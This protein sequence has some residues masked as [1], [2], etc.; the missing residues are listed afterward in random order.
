[1]IVQLAV[2]IGHFHP[3]LVHLP[4]GILIFAFILE[5][6]LRNKKTEASEDIIKFA[7]GI[8]AL[9]ALMSLG[10]G[11]LLGD[12]GGYD[13]TALFR[14]KWMAVAMTVCSI[15]L[16]LLKRNST[17]WSQKTYFPLF[18]ITL[19]LLGITGHLGGN[20][21]HGEGYLFQEKTSEE[22]VITDVNSAKVYADIIQ[23]IFDNKCVSC[24]NPKKAKGELLMTDKT[25]LLAGGENGSILDSVNGNPSSLLTRIHLDVADEEHMPPKGKVQLTEEEITLLDWWMANENCFDCTAGFLNKD[26]HIKTI[27]KSL[28]KDTSTWGILAEQVGSVPDEWIDQM[29]SL[30]LGTERLDENSPL[31]L[32]NLSN[33]V[34][35]DKDKLSELKKYAENV[36]ELNLGYSGFNDTMANGISRFKNLTK[37]QLQRTKITDKTIERLKNLTYLESLNLYGTAITDKSLGYLKKMKSLRSLYLY[38]TSITNNQLAI[39]KTEAPEVTYKH[40]DDAIFTDASLNKPYVVSGTDFFH[41]TQKIELEHAFKS[42]NLYYTTDNSEPN[43]NSKKYVGPIT[44]D[45]STTIKVLAQ[46]DDWKNSEVLTAKFKKSGVAYDTVWLNKTPHKNY[47]GKGG[48]T[49]VDLTRGS[50]SFQDGKWLG[51][52]GTHFKTTMTLKE[53]KEIST[54]S[55]GALT[56]P[57]SWIFYPVGFNVWTS[58]NGKDYKLISTKQNPVQKESN[59]VE[60]TFF[61]IEFK[62]TM[63]RYVKLEI[64]SI[65]KNPSWHPNPGGESW[66]FVDEI[67]IN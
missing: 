49:L 21:T 66:V 55:V 10:T 14:H 30:G 19:A 57:S 59:N 7:L 15:L 63:A 45:E 35:I 4:I 62:P 51:F 9:S 16:Y 50:S 29:N 36:V 48:K 40:L 39:F 46:K 41:D 37:L 32:V 33:K 20:M 8:A 54:V 5:I 43:T 42:A 61:D 2:Q 67:I 22:I 12:D 47:S 52:Q 28:E 25:N 34:D 26:K 13:E 38:E 18:I 23:P 64:K 11:W 60:T 58:T 31:L 65:L 1:M 27:L 24:H 3:L 44:I 17:N 53:T 56:S 6:F